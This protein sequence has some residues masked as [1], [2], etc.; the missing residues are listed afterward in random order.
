MK[1]NETNPQIR[2]QLT[3]IDEKAAVIV[4]KL[5]EQRIKEEGISPT[6]EQSRMLLSSKGTGMAQNPAEGMKNEMYFSSQET[7][8]FNSLKK[9]DRPTGLIFKNMD[10]SVH[11]N[12]TF[13]EEVSASGGYSYIPN[14][15]DVDLF[16]LKKNNV[17]LSD[18]WTRTAQIAPP[19]NFE[20]GASSWYNL[21]TFNGWTIKSITEAMQPPGA[22]PCAFAIS[23]PYTATS[24]C[25][26]VA[27]KVNS[28]RLDGV[29]TISD[30]SGNIIYKN[31]R[32]FRLKD[33]PNSNSVDVFFTDSY[34]WTKTIAKREVCVVY[35]G[36]LP[37]I[38][39]NKNLAAD[40]MWAAVADKGY[41]SPILS[42]ITNNFP[43]D[44]PQNDWHKLLC[45]IICDTEINGKKTAIIWAELF[46]D[47]LLQEG[48]PINIGHHTDFTSAKFNPDGLSVSVKKGGE[49]L[50]Q[51]DLQSLISIGPA[52]IVS[53]PVI[54]GT[55]D[56]KG[57]IPSKF[58]L[59]QNYPN[60]FN[61]ATKLRFS[62]PKDSDISLKIYNSIGQEVATLA[63]GHVQAGNHE[64]E[65]NAGK[66]PS[67]IY[68]ARLTFGNL[69][70]SVKMVLLK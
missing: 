37:N 18:G 28:N 25:E 30:N 53:D 66:L 1:Q 9:P 4:P 42:I 68:V 43:T 20:N 38:P 58:S 6:P 67:G 69:Q 50:G 8:S 24:K 10:I 70:E 62:L 39:T 15:G 65:F 47:K 56:I 35:I 61:P 11:K 60:P 2:V 33:I 13:D 51:M 36:D 16:P 44:R 34:E 64:V 23:W 52:L 27:N 26:F 54:S 57:A 29:L 49:C 55:P 63:D 32:V 31:D 21:G 3:K 14:Y 40:A 41:P 5:F 7:K 59:E 19:E 45:H 46:S 48:R 17:V 12:W 22:P